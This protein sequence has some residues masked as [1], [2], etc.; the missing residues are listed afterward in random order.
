MK[1]RVLRNCY[2]YEILYHEGEVCELSDKAEI[3]EKNFELLDKPL[4]DAPQAITEAVNDED[5]IIP[6][7]NDLTCPKC[8]KVCKSEFGLR[9]HSKSHKK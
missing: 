7:T 1:Y 4:P 9:S 8:G 3:C 5:A 6:S 2:V